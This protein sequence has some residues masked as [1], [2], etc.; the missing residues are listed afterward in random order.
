MSLC[1]NRIHKT[2]CPRARGL[3][4]PL[5]GK[6]RQ[7]AQRGSLI[8]PNASTVKTVLERHKRRLRFFFLGVRVSH[9][10][11]TIG[12]PGSAAQGGLIFIQR[13]GSERS[14]L[15]WETRCSAS[16]SSLESPSTRRAPALSWA[17][18]LDKIQAISGDVCNA[19]A[20]RSSRT[21][22]ACCPK[23]R[24]CRAA[25]ASVSLFR[26][27]CLTLPSSAR[28]RRHRSAPFNCAWQ[29]GHCSMC[30]VWR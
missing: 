9:R 5:H 22:L 29:I 13:R 17:W 8:K 20:R 23:D 14:S 28:Q 2:P 10:K 4:L 3:H 19:L 21:A 11:L 24:K 16:V 6:L 1:R 30:Q 18:I 26:L 7:H 15:Y 27:M 12:C 25:A